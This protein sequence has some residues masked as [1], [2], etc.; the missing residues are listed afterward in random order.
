MAGVLEPEEID[1]LMDGLSSGD[2]DTNQSHSDSKGL[3]G[4]R[5]YVWEQDS[6]RARSSSGQQ[7][8]IQTQLVNLVCEPLRELCEGLTLSCLD[9]G[10]QLNGEELKATLASEY[11]TISFNHNGHGGELLCLLNARLSYQWVDRFY[12]GSGAVVQ[13]AP[14]FTATEKRLLQGF[15]ERLASSISEHWPDSKGGS[16]E[17]RGLAPSL[18]RLEDSPWC[19]DLIAAKADLDLDQQSYDVYWLMPA[20]T[21][22]VLQAK[23]A[24]GQAQAQWQAQMQQSLLDAPLPMTAV[25]G[26]RKISLKKL[27]ELGVGDVID[28][29]SPEHV[30]LSAGSVPLICADFGAEDGVVSVRVKQRFNPFHHSSKPAPQK[31]DPLS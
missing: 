22:Q 6:P 3:G 2:V 28:I 25:L 9:T 5:P 19:D 13:T 24:N 11:W 8:E 14:A 17:C 27:S 29:E 30:L 26:R 21:T 7:T 4:V 12:G 10:V 16:W 18:K 23:P 31:K 1:A 20:G 15:C